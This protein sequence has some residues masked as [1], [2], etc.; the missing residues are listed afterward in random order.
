[1]KWKKKKKRQIPNVRISLY[2]D[3]IFSKYISLFMYMLSSGSSYC[4]A[5][6]FSLTSV[7]HS[8]YMCRAVVWKWRQL[9]GKMLLYGLMLLVCAAWGKCFIFWNSYRKEADTGFQT[10]I[11]I[12]PSWPN[13]SWENAGKQEWRMFKKKKSTKFTIVLKSLIGYLVLHLPDFLFF[14]IHCI[15][16]SN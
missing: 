4:I 9:M 8:P 3:L 13:V 6:A 12:C 16:P 10:C 5:E 7:A 14:S 2:W 11:L 15:F 1:M